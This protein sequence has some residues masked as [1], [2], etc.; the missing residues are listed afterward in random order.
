MTG[1]GA[2]LRRPQPDRPAKLTELLAGFGDVI[3]AAGGS[4]VLPYATV[5]V[6]ATRI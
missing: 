2:D 1:A 6:T 4:F 3:D 5:A